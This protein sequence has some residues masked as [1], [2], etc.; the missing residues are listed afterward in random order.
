MFTRKRTTSTSD[1]RNFDVSGETFKVSLAEDG[2][3]NGVTWY[4]GAS[5]SFLGA[6]R[7]EAI[8][9]P[10]FL[11]AVESAALTTV[12][13]VKG[14]KLTREPRVSKKGTAYHAWTVA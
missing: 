13:A 12:S 7:M 10:A 11:K 4:S 1:P 3:P 14:G 8:G 2:T 6:S 9:N 5:Q